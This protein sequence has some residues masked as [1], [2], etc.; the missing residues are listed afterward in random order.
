[1][2]ENDLMNRGRGRPKMRRFEFYRMPVGIFQTQPMRRLRR[3]CGY[4]G[5]AVY[6]QLLC[7]VY[8]GDL[9]YYLKVDPDELQEL[10]E[11]VA[12][13]LGG[14]A[15]GSDVAKAFDHM[16]SSGVI[17][18]EL[19]R[20]EGV[21]TSAEIQIT[22]EQMAAAARRSVVVVEEY[23][24]IDPGTGSGK[25][26][27][28]SSEEN[29]ISSEEN[30]FSSEENVFSSEKSLFSS[31]K[32]KVKEKES[33]EKQQQQQ[34]K[35]PSGAAGEGGEGVT[36]GEIETLVAQLRDHVLNGDGNAAFHQR[37]LLVEW[38]KKMELPCVAYAIEKAAGKENPMGYLIATLQG[39][40]KDGMTTAAALPRDFKTRGTGSGAWKD[41]AAEA[42]Y[43]DYF[44]GE[45]DLDPD[46]LTR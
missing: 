37:Q 5:Q 25:K 18:A 41:E 35:E 14:D 20:L 24:L 1:M 40:E 22:Y 28:I 29:I 23:A 32:R 26:R 6:T 3:K 27:G 42:M 16:A 19:Y 11:D 34:I 36:I 8:G 45:D 4:F 21:I 43:A 9:G 13:L 12:E 10:C 44:D 30:I 2:G 15:T 31:A 38:S 46:Y 17:D 7:M 39:M 33:K